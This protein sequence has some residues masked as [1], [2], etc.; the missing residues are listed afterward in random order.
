MISMRVGTRLL[1]YR[2]VVCEKQSE[3]LSALLGKTRTLSRSQES[4]PYGF[5]ND[6]PLSPIR[7]WTLKE[8]SRT[9]NTENTPLSTQVRSNFKEKNLLERT[10]MID[11]QR[12]DSIVEGVLAGNRPTSNPI[13]NGDSGSRY[14]RGVI[15]DP[16]STVRSSMAEFP[17]K[18]TERKKPLVRATLRQ[19]GCSRRTISFPWEWAIYSSLRPQKES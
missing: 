3:Q 18:L 1:T 4:F 12:Q 15:S 7:N 2:D 13:T 5:G 19:C 6:S 16:W 11:L 10:D 8:S 9:K 17:L 14:V